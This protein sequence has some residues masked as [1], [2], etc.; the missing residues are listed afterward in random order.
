MMVGVDDMAPTRRALHAV[1]ELVLAGP[2]YR[3]TG[4]IRLHVTEHGFAT[5]REP[6]VAVEG[7]ELV[8]A[9]LRIGIDERTCAELAAMLGVAAGKPENLYDDGSG[10]AADEV[11][12]ADSAIAAYLAE[13]FVRGD[14]ALRRFAPEVPDDERVLWPEHFDVGITV[15]E[16][17][18]GVS[19]G[20]G[21]LDEPYAYVGPWQ[22]R[23]GGFWNAPFGAT[24]LMRDLPDAAAVVAFFAEG[25]ARAQE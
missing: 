3:R 19:P 1:A 25:R 10:V 17:N 16:I 6:T 21:Y 7:A 4:T 13:C 24:R 23:Q 8:A 15:A 12:E 9:G 14:Q 2:Q 18:Y 20:D 22:P 11:L 5:N